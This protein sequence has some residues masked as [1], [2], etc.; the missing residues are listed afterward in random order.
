MAV[1]ILEMVEEQVKGNGDALCHF[2][3]YGNSYVP[4]RHWPR[5]PSLRQTP[6]LPPHTRLPSHETSDLGRVRKPGEPSRLGPP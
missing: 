5:R 2:V 1:G 3:A 6:P 4:H